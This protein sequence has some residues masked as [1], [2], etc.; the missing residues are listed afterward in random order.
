MTPR[1]L[2]CGEPHQTKECQIK[3]VE[4]LF[5]INCES[6]GHMANYNKF[7]FYPKTRKGTTI[8]LNYSNIVNSLI[9]P[10]ISYAQITQPTLNSTTPQQMAPQIGT[11]PAITQPMNQDIITPILS[12]QQNSNTRNECFNLISH[13]LLQTIQALFTLVQKIS[14]MNFSDATPPPI[15]A[16]KNKIKKSKIKVILES[17]TE[18]E[19]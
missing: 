13:T 17:R 5:Y 4:T 15:I 2:K 1:C 6:F 16:G 7:P 8:N 19:E 12:H 11:I 14:L 9:R 18:E 3:K 10:T